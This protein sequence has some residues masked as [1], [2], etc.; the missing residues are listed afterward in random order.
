MR[1]I[2]DFSDWTV[3]RTKKYLEDNR[4]DGVECPAC[5]VFYR[6]Y[7]WTFY[8]TAARGL[9]LLNRLGG[10]E[11]YVFTGDLKQKYGFKGQGDCS[12]WRFFGL[13]TEDRDRKSNTG[14]AGYWKLTPLGV[15]FING[16]A[17]IPKKVYVVHSK[18][19][20]SE[21]PH[22]TVQQALGKR[23]DYDELMST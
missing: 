22:V 3:E 1:I 19:T 12:R 20:R 15:D 7:K 2:R 21:G 6:E 10:A 8:S 13:A 17:T 18:P 11:D 9:I 4:K 14:R 16:R 23:F 5:G